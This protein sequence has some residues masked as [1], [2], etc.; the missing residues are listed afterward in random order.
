MP[1]KTDDPTACFQREYLDK[2]AQTCL[3]ERVL[4]RVV[5]QRMEALGADTEGCRDIL[6]RVGSVDCQ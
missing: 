4:A 6:E 2:V 3:P 1:R 5:L